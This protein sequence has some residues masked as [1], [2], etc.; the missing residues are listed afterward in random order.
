MMM[1]IQPDGSCT[2]GEHMCNVSLLPQEPVACYDTKIEKN[3][4]YFSYGTSHMHYEIKDP[5]S[6]VD[7]LQ[8]IC[9]STRYSDNILGN[10]ILFIKYLGKEYTCVNGNADLLS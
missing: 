9:M 10:D 8:F 5:E 6:N 2:I 3:G 1:T 7:E 4:E